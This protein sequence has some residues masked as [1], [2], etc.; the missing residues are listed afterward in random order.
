MG[1]TRRRPVDHP[2]LYPTVCRPAF[3]QDSETSLG[4]MPRSLIP[5]R[6]VFCFKM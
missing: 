2:S 3:L 6:P 5:P 4:D 1:F